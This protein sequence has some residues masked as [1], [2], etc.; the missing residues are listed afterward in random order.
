MNGPLTHLS[1]CSRESS[2]IFLSG[3]WRIHHPSLTALLMLYCCIYERMSHVT[4]TFLS[5]RNVTLFKTFCLHIT[6][7]QSLSTLDTLNILSDF[8]IFWAESPRCG[9][10]QTWPTWSLPPSTSARWRGCPSWAPTPARTRTT[11]TSRRWAEGSRWNI[12]RGVKMKHFQFPG[13]SVWAVNQP[14][15]GITYLLLSR[16][17]Q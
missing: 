15:V 8:Q 7:N 13:P 2:W 9:C 16:L 5:L 6:L 11:S 14:S 17:I 10:L 4:N 12:I 1:R 3:Y